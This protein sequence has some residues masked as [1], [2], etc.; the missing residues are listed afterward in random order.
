LI[1]FVVNFSSKPVGLQTIPSETVS[2]M[3]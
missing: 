1:D 3:T 2:E